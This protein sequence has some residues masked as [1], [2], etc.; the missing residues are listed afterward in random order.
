MA[1]TSTLRKLG[2]ETTDETPVADDRPRRKSG[3]VRSIE[4]QAKSVERLPVDLQKAKAALKAANDNLT[5]AVVAKRF[6]VAPGLDEKRKS[7][8]AEVERLQAVIEALGCEP[9]EMAAKLREKAL[10]V[11]AR[12]QARRNEAV[13]PMTH[14]VIEAGQLTE[15]CK[16]VGQ[17]VRSTGKA[18]VRNPDGTFGPAFAT[19]RASKAA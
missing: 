5:E 16:A 6:S 1:R 3:A 4:R 7:A 8:L 9:A 15:V 19:K 12:E 10:A 18:V 13:T 14:S 11:A 17:P 2:L